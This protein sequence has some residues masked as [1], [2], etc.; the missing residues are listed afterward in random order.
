MTTNSAIF[1][2]PG[3]FLLA[4]SIALFLATKQFTQNHLASVGW[5]RMYSVSWNG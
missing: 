5:H 3:V 4:V 1:H 2:M